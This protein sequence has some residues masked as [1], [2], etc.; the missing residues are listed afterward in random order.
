LLPAAHI[1]SAI[2]FNRLAYHDEHLGPSAVGALTPDMAD[3][4]FAWVLRVTST[5]H[6]LAHTLLAGSGFTLLVMQICGLRTARSFGSAYLLHLVGDDIHHGRVP[7]L[8]PFSARKRRPRARG[9]RQLTTWAVGFLLELPALVLL[10]LLARLR[11]RASTTEAT[12][13]PR[14]AENASLL[15]PPL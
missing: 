14:G 10:I 13:L 11:G 2:L 1:A 6:H 9:R 8:M 12:T 5:R 3:T 15:F 4:T 7:W